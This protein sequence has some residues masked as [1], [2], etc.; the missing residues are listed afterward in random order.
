MEVL[1][2]LEYNEKFPKPYI[3]L[4]GPTPRSKSVE[5]WRPEALEL[6]KT[7]EFLG[8]IFIPEPRHGW[9]NNMFSGEEGKISYDWKIIIDWELEHLEKADVILFWIPREIDAMPAFT[10]NVE[11]GF[12]LKSDKAMYGRPDWA[13]KNGYLDYLYYKTCKRK[14]HNNLEDLVADSINRGEVKIALAAERNL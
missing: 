8:T 2:T 4:A 3:F 12:W 13:P 1:Y 14:P 6:F 9:D 11:F 10:T 5:S 7:L